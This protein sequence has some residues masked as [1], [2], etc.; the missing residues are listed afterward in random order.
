MKSISARNKGLITGI[1][2]VA[3]SLF[4]YY[5]LNK[6]FESAF[7]YIIYLIYTAGIVWTLIDFKNNTPDGITFKT[8]FAEGFKMFVVTTLIMVL[9]VISFFYLNPE[10]RDAKFAENTKLLLEEGNHTAAEIENNTKMMKRSLST[11]LQ[12]FLEYHSLPLVKISVKRC[13]L[14]P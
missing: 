14:E 10:I 6:P 5:V 13:A 3:L 4:F 12:P 1:L 8:Y 11:R 7:Q 9:F 2:M